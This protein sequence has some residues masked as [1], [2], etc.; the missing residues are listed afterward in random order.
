MRNSDEPP[1]AP[2]QVEMPDYRGMGLGELSAA[3]V[4]K[5]IDIDRRGGDWMIRRLESDY[6]I[7]STPT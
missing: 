3:C 4:A 2:V 7:G 5:G 6:G 1:L